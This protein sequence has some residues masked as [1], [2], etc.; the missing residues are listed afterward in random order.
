MSN[1]G[2]DL[3]FPPSLSLTPAKWHDVMSLPVMMTCWVRFC[4]VI[5]YSNY[6][7]SIRYFLWVYLVLTL[8]FLSK[9]TKRKGRFMAKWWCANWERLQRR[10]RPWVLKQVEGFSFTIAYP[11]HTVHPRRWLMHAVVSWTNQRNEHRIRSTLV[12]N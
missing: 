7:T 8:Q 11:L 4:E 3:P 5:T 10:S 6:G 9:C 2:L 1:Q 12:D